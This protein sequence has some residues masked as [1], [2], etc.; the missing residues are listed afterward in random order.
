M[1][2]HVSRD[3]WLLY[4]LDGWQLPFIVE[5]SIRHHGVYAITL[6]RPTVPTSPCARGCVNDLADCRAN[7]CWWYRRRA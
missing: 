3:G 1:H 2:L 7:G 5:P 6:E 4:L